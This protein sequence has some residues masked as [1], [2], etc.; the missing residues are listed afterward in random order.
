MSHLIPAFVIT[1]LSS[2]LV[3]IPSLQ[4]FDSIGQHLNS[5]S[6]TS[7][8]KQEAVQFSSQSFQVA[9]NPETSNP[10]GPSRGD[11]RREASS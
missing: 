7:S 1:A 2:G 3:V 6:E 5:N 11:T 9:N 10:K 4:E 8:I